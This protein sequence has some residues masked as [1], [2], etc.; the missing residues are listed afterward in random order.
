[1]YCQFGVSLVIGWLGMGVCQYMH[2]REGEQ[3]FAALTAIIFFSLIN[4]V[5][6]LAYESYL[7]YTVPSYGLYVLL[8][9]VIF[10]SAKGLS[11]ISINK[12]P[13]YRMMINSISIFFFI[14]STM[15]RGMRIIYDAAGEGL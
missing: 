5:V 7:R 3:Y 8:I 10:L 2:V 12:L 11:G 15:I 9:A 14:G 6:S 1:M 4:V 13:E